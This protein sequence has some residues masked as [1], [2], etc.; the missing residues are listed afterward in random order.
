[1]SEPLEEDGRIDLDEHVEA[2]IVQELKLAGEKSVRTTS[3]KVRKE[4][5]DKLLEMK[6][7]QYL[8]DIIVGNMQ[9]MVVD[10]AF[11]SPVYNQAFEL[12][13]KTYVAIW[14]AC[15]EDMS[16]AVFAKIAE[17]ICFEVP[18]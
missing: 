12:A 1:M 10:E 6:M 14:T 13:I 18:F 9:I 16:E 3:H 8:V 2:E 15:K 11:H 5:Y 17:N 4:F 7:P